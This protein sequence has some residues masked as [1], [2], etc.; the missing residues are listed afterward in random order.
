MTA[1][2]KR[3]W[4]GHFVKNL[5]PTADGS[6]EWLIWSRYHNAW[7]CRSSIGGACGYT[8]DIARAGVFE[9]SKADGYN[10]G[11][12]NE[13]FHVSEKLP[14]LHAAIRQ[15]N[16]A[17]ENLLFA[18]AIAAGT[19]RA[20]T[21]ETSAPSEVDRW[22]PITGYEGF[23][24]VSRDGRV[25]SHITNREMAPVANSS[26][27]PHPHWRLRER[28]RELPDNSVDSVVCDPPYHLTS[29]VKRF[30]SANALPPRSARRALMPAQQGLHGS[31][32]G[33][34]RCRVP[35]RD[36]GRSAARAEAWRASVAFSGTRTYHRMAVAI[37]DAGF[38]VRDMIAWHYGSGFP[39]SHDI[40]KAIDRAA[41]AEREVVGPKARRSSA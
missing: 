3:N 10:D 30:G 24:S 33:R 22:R 4:R 31:D 21:S 5:R 27:R 15:H 39:K 36:M 7:H 16:E 41:G 35:A 19:Q 28:L 8:D 1:T 32:M 6:R 9:R 23:Y 38:E 20:E 11:D 12:R 17:L 2:R 29:I 26:E 37:E 14:L 18:A 25:F 34:R 13:A 40:S